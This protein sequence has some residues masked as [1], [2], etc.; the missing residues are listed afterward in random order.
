MHLYDPLLR[1]KI[2]TTT[3]RSP[4]FGRFLEDQTKLLI[5]CENDSDYKC[6][7]RSVSFVV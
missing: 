3:R 4:Y 5:E 7:A 1:R 6:P 2:A